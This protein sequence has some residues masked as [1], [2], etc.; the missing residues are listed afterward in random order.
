M[1][2]VTNIA[3]ARRER[4]RTSEVESEFTEDGIAGER[5]VSN[6]P[7]QRQFLRVENFDEMQSPKRPKRPTWIK[8]FVY[9]LDDPVRL[10]LTLA[11]RGF[12]SEFE[13]LA[14][15]MGNR[16]PDDASFIGRKINA[17]PAV[18]GKALVSCMYHGLITRFAEDL[19]ISR[20]NDLHQKIDTRPIPPSTSYSTSPYQ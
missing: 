16:V 2:K 18:V 8:S 7:E 4:S 15:I 14:A 20:I 9:D 5:C 13:K 10:N 12:L 1:N 3:T 11:V 6:A 19:N 17:N